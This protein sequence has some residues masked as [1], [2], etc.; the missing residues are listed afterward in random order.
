MTL[1]DLS[2]ANRL[3]HE[4]LGRSLDELPPQTRRVLIALDE[5][6]TEAC[7]REDI[8]RSD[9]RFTRRQ[10][11]ER[12]GLGN[13]QAKIHL[14]RLEELE[15]V[16]GHAGERGRALYELVYDGQGKDGTPFLTGL[17]DVGRLGGQGYDERWS[18]LAA[19]W[20]GGRTH[21]SG[22]GRPPAG[23]EPGGGRGDEI[24]VSSSNDG[25]KS[26]TSRANG[27]IARPGGGLVAPPP[28]ACRGEARDGP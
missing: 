8:A 28:Y 12:T 11:R 20:S 9:W 6:A 14:A 3:A 4:V 1:S 10:V 23:P 7:A 27:S 21:R 15:Y 25:A 18:A 19:G 24:A 5:M 26:A 16:L 17:I 22:P 2:P 13:T